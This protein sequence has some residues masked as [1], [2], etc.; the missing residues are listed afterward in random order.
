MRRQNR[1]PFSDEKETNKIIYLSISI[2]VIDGKFCKY[3]KT[4]VRNCQ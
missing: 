2:D 4:P 3:N 1:R